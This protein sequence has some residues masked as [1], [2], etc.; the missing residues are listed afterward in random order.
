MNTPKSWK[1]VCLV[2]VLALA[3]GPVAW[4]QTPDEKT[5]APAEKREAPVEE[6]D[7]PIEQGPNPM[8]VATDALI[9]RPVGLIMIPVTAIIY[10]ISYPFS[11]ASGNEEEAYQALVGNTIDYTFDRPLGGG[12]PFDGLP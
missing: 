2:I 9:L 11:K 4:A 12:A 1:T 8:N 5:G 3:L 6:D 7:A 10:V